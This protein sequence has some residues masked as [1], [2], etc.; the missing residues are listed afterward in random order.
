MPVLGQLLLRSARALE[1]STTWAALVGKVPSAA[2]RQT[3]MSRA[4]GFFMDFFILF[5]PV[6]PMFFDG[7]FYPGNSNYQ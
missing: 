4:R 1:G 7:V 2:I 5:P 3:A 6:E